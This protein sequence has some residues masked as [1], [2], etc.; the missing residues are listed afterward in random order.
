MALLKAQEAL[1]SRKIIIN[2]AYLALF[3]IR[4]YQ[5]DAVKIRAYRQNTDL[6]FD[7]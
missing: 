1:A 7:I 4:R 6:L 5:R 2:Q 3:L